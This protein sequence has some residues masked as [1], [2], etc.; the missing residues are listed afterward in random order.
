MASHLNAFLLDKCAGTVTAPGYASFLATCQQRQYGSS[1]IVRVNLLSRR[2]LAC[3]IRLAK[4][5]RFKPAMLRIM[6]HQEG[7]QCR[8]ELAGRLCGPWVG[9]T[10]RV[11][12]SAP[13]SGKELEVDMTE[14]TGVDAAGRQLLAAMHRAGARLIAKGVW[15]TALVVEVT[16]DQPFDGN[17][18][19]RRKNPSQD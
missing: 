7:S 5:M 3:S 9:E 1:S 19:D 10:E 2:I 16:G 18:R 6:V 14:V 15:M 12:R 13:H 11:W 17:Q 4:G 8:L